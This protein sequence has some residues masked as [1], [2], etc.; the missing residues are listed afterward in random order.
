MIID[1]Y[2]EFEELC[3]LGNYD[4]IRNYIIQYEIN[5]NMFDGF[6]I[7]VISSHNDLDLFKLFIEYGA[8]IS[9]D[10]YRC[11]KLIAYKGFYNLLLY[12]LDAYEIPSDIFTKNTSFK[13]HDIIYKIICDKYNII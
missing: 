5:V 12:I 13:N 4:D 9:L 2:D 8:D 10:D 7:S 6:L 1:I 3:Y 11:V